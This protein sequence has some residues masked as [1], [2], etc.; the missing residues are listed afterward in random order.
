MST[1]HLFRFLSQRARGLVLL[2]IG[3]GALSG[4]FSVGV[5]ALINR[6]LVA[7]RGDDAI[8][9]LAGAFAALVLGKVVTNLAAQLLLVRFSQGTILDLSLAL[10][11]KIIKAPLRRLETRGPARVLA[12]LTDDVGTI[13]WAVQC[14]PR[15]AMN[16][17]LVLGCAIYLAWLSWQ[18]FLVLGV[19]TLCGALL[20]KLM[21]D[22]A[23]GLME[24]AREARSQL[25]RNFSDLV[26]GSKELMLH[27]QRSAAFLDRQIR[28]TAEA[29][30]R[31][32]LA[33]TRRYAIA[34]AWIQL[35]FYAL[36]GMLIFIVPRLAAPSMHTLTGYVFTLVY[37]M[38]PM[39][40]LIG[41]VPTIGRGQ[42]ALRQ[43]EALGVH[44][45]A[46]DADA[47][48]S[49]SAREDPQRTR[50]IEMRQA[51]FSYGDEPGDGFTLGPIDFRLQ[52]GEL[53]FV[54]GGNGS[55]KSTFVKLLTG[56]YRPRGGTLAT[57][58][59]GVAGADLDWYR[60]HFSVVFSD[61]HLFDKLLGL[62]EAE[63]A[64]KTER[65]LKALRLDH[66]VQVRDGG[67]STVDL[68]QGQRKRLALVTA[69]L[70]DRPFYVFDE[71]AADQDPEYKEI[72]YARLLPDLRR[73]GKGV[74]VVT[75]DDRYFHL[76]DRIVKLEDGRLTQAV[77]TAFEDRTRIGTGHRK[78]SSAAA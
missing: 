6:T 61:F 2:M 20:Y 55:G 65:Y 50:V 29:Y 70:E 31:S 45:D 24:A 63:L 44:L 49:A 72:F 38:G 36:I 57:D 77:D 60:Q 52:R 68:S 37:M 18:I 53:V 5:V 73:L 39:W 71:W 58:G 51:V 16:A 62:P 35:L 48:G 40:S 75:H 46:G 4:L 64:A 9:L 10:S 41:V 67:F 33:A 14:L 32:N 12:T 66:K 22:R 8:L 59:A 47:G 15:F 28:P 34:D 54:A 43:I 19:L 23:F 1:S 78:V 13:T 56:L 25:F 26:H 17:A 7:Q 42:I 3:V 30:R 74:V 27:R 21:H 76:G 11:E 69:Y